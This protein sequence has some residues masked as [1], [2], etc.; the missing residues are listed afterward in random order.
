MPGFDS[1]HVSYR[2]PSTSVGG[3]VAVLPHF[4][5]A[6]T[7]EGTFSGVCVKNSSDLGEKKMYCCIIYVISF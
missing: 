4:N 1:F 2:T 3:D 7:T 5:F 6:I